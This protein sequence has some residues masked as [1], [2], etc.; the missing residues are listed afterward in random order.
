MYSMQEPRASKDVPQE[1]RSPEVVARLCTL[2]ELAVQLPWEGMAQQLA[3]LAGLTRLEVH[4]TCGRLS[5]GLV[6]E[7]LEAAKGVQGLRQLGMPSSCWEHGKV[8]ELRK[9]RPGLGLRAVPE[10]EM[11]H[12]LLA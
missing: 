10:S 12:E 4:G 9:A 8:A 3:G 11:L 6:P 7:V 5:S 1:L 2:R